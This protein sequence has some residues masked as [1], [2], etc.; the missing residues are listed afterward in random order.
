MPF[1]KRIQKEYPL[2]GGG[3]FDA[4]SMLIFGCVGKKQLLEK[5]L[6][7]VT[8]TLVFM[9]SCYSPLLWGSDEIGM[10]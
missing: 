8:E 5:T 4:N 10:M 6:E 7:I 2:P 3:I 1:S 9:K